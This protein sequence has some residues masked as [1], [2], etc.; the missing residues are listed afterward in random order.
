MSNNILITG[1]SGFIG[2]HLTLKLL[3]SGFSVVGI[4]N[5]NDY[6]EVSLKEARLNEI[7]RLSKKNGTNFNFKKFDI[8]IPSK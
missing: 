1:V 6:Y 8:K 5:M 2:F 3:E 7:Y 4:D